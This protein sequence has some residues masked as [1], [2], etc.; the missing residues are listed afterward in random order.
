MV[1]SAIQLVTAK[2]HNM[3]AVA[4]GEPCLPEEPTVYP[5]VARDQ[6]VPDGGRT[7]GNREAADPRG[8]E[9]GRT[10]HCALSQV[11]HH[12]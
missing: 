7:F 8:I 1:S 3:V 6:G 10:P 4:E 12:L 5:A 2:E 11:G 9:A